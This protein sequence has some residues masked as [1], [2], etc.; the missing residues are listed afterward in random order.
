M[1]VRQGKP[2]VALLV[3]LL[4]LIAVCRLVPMAHE[5]TGDEAH[6]AHV[7]ALP[8]DALIETSRGDTHPPLYYA[9]LGVMPDTMGGAW[10]LR[11]LSFL[12]SLAQLAVLWAIGRHM[13]GAR[14]GWVLVA[15]GGV[16][17]WFC[18]E[19][20]TA[21]NY[22]ML[23]LL[24][25]TAWLVLLHARERGG[26]WRWGLV[27]LLYAAACWTFY[28]AAHAIAALTV[29][30]LCTRPRKK[31][32]LAYGL[33][34][35]GAVL[36][37]LPWVPS[38]LEQI[39]RVR[40]ASPGAGK[41]EWGL[42]MFVERIL[43]RHLFTSGP[44]GSIIALG[45][46]AGVLLPLIHHRRWFRALP[47]DAG[48]S[49]A[50]RWLVPTGVAAATYLLVV[51]ASTA[52]GVFMR[53]HY[54]GFLGTLLCVFVGILLLQLP[55]RICVLLVAALVV[56]G[57]TYTIKRTLRRA[58]TGAEPATRVVLA[59]ASEDDVVLCLNADGKLLYDYFRQGRGPEAYGVYDSTPRGGP[60][61]R[62][63][64]LALDATDPEIL[65][66]GGSLWVLWVAPALAGPDA[67][68]R[69]R[70]LLALRAWRSA[71]V[72]SWPRGA[73]LERFVR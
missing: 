51:V 67:A 9:L 73:R 53:P 66:R 54:A 71:E 32:G 33:A 48:A 63:P 72:R 30:F 55:R 59:Q 34:I 46:L 24:V 13:G 42:D 5:V 56:A 44:W 20:A 1:N 27:A 12:C 11:L 35:V 2:T 70:A 39:E 57:A 14:L 58:E 18:R 19:G 3:A 25:T 50:R 4:L 10:P 31:Q 15:L 41:A 8:F 6:S 60:P 47:P 62:R 43:R 16:N 45:V 7:A 61:W 21:R 36:L 23:Q 26:A 52:A 28:Y 38:L 68:E 17:L 22:G 49:R 69:L 37:F 64:S 65:H 29:F 40:A